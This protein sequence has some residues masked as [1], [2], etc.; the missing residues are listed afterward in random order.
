MYQRFEIIGRVVNL[1]EMRYTP[2]ATPIHAVTN[3]TVAVNEKWGEREN[4][5][6]VRVAT[7]NGLAE[8]C[9][10]YVSKGM[11]IFVEG[12]INVDYA[13]N[14]RSFIRKDGTAG[15]SLEMTASTVKFLSKGERVES[16][17]E[18]VPF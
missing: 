14:P 13:G 15:A 5:V 4:T 9:N 11:L 8:V 1:P 7:W 12:R 17:D 10:K 2:D 3:F 6:W 16:A 18:F